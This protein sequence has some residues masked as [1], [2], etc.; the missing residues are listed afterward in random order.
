MKTLFSYYV[1][2]PIMESIVGSF[3][4]PSH[5]AAKAIFEKSVLDNE[6]F[7][8]YGNTLKCFRAAWTF[9]VP[10]TYSDINDDFIEEDFYE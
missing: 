4:A 10:E 7:K 2:D 5:A 8:V 3:Q 9:M 6:K 1:V